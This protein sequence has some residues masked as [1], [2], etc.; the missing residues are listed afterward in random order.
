M[1]QNTFKTFFILSFMPYI[2]VFLLGLGAA[3]QGATFLG[4][5]LYYGLEGF[6]IGII[7]GLIYLSIVVPIIPICLCFQ[8]G[9]AI[10]KLKNRGRKIEEK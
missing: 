7:G 2:L 1:K 3:F 6:E 9:Y 5:T 8:L 4:D 10:A